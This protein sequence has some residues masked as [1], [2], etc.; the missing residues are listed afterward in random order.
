MPLSGAKNR[1][2]QLALILLSLHASRQ[3]SKMRG[4][5]PP[6]RKRQP[7]THAG[8][9]FSPCPPKLCRFFATE[10]GGIQVFRAVHLALLLV[11]RSG[12]PAA[13]A[14]RSPA[15]SGNAQ[16]RDHLRTHLIA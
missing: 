15:T 5:G 11:L 3:C 1:V 8:P 12:V 10:F 14:G 13:P 4:Q 6:L 16:G 9:C 2:A 7:C